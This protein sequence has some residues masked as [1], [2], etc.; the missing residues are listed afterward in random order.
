[1]GTRVAEKIGILGGSFDPIHIGHLIIAQEIMER[2]ALHEVLFV[3]CSIPPHKRSAAIASANSRLKMVELAVE[4]DPRFRACDMEIRRG[5]ISYSIDT[6]DELRESRGPGAE[7]FFI[8]GA[9]SLL[10]IA[11]WKDYKRL[12]SSCTVVTAARSGY[13]L[14][15]WPWPG[16][17]LNPEEAE[18]IRAH[19]MPTPLIEVS[20][21]D[22]RLR[23]SQGRS[24][25]YMVPPA[26]ERFIVLEN[27]YS[28]GAAGVKR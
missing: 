13:D 10:E 3:P 7:F 19:I 27:L 6:I 12:A 25:M 15:G 16:T 1:M 20:S 26:V 23:R 11:T 21:T 17:G 4:G 18:R 28:G 5:G 24:I 2:L 14:S 8:I 22:I 9:D